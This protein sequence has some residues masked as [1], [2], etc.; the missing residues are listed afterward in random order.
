MSTLSQHELISALTS[1]PEREM[2]AVLAVALEK[3]GAAARAARP[4]AEG[5]CC[6]LAFTSQARRVIC[7]LCGKAARAT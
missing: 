5:R 2:A 7:P 1:L 4:A 3:R 6:G